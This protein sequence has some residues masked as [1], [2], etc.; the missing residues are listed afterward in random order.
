MIMSNKTMRRMI[1]PP[2]LVGVILLA[3]L[4]GL[5][6]MGLDGITKVGKLKPLKPVPAEYA[7]KHMPKGW[8]TDP[9]IIAEGKQ[10]YEGKANAQVF[11]FACH[12]QNGVPTV[13]GVRDLRADRMKR[14]SDSYWFWRISEGLPFTTMK[15]WKTLLTEEERWKV[16]AYEH[17]FSHGGKAED[18]DHSEIEWRVAGEGASSS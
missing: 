7:D 14:M 6:T 18:H 11:C 15:D 9:K 10:I 3:A 17:Q 5:A 13:K 4:G 8:W 16:M 2:I 1:A 12:G